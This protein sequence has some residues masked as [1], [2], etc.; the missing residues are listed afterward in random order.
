MWRQIEALE[1]IFAMR[2]R[3]SAGLEK[4][5]FGRKYV[6]PIGTLDPTY[7]IRMSAAAMVVCI[8]S[9]APR[10]FMPQ[11]LPRRPCRR[12]S[13]HRGGRP[14]SPA[15][16][17]ENAAQAGCRRWRADAADRSGVRI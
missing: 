13:P 16:A 7:Q 4:K 12:A 1:N 14:R 6:P 17:R 8:S 15:A 10:L 2:A 11:H 5:N 9:N 3:T